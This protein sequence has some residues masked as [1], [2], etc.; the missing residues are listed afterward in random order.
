VDV[1]VD[2]GGIDVDVN[3][4]RARRERRQLAGHAIVESR[5]DV[6]HEIAIVHRVV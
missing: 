1:L 3:L 5:A 4:L 2:R 6:D